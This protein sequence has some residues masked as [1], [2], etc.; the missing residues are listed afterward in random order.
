MKKKYVSPESEY[1]DF[2][3]QDVVTEVLPI[4]DYDTPPDAEGGTV[5]SDVDDLFGKS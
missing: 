2:K 4:D 3:A 1:I 5:K